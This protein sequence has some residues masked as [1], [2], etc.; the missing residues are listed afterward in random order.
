[1]IFLLWWIYF[2][3]IARRIPKATRMAPWAYLHLPLVMS[4]VAISA[5]I[6]NLFADM[7]VIVSGEVRLLLAGA[8]GSALIIIAIL[9]FTLTPVD[10]L[11]DRNRYIS[12]GLKIITGV[13]AFAVG[14]L[15]VGLGSL[16]LLTILILLML[17]HIFY[18]AFVW[19]GYLTEMNRKSDDQ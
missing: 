8:L 5:S 12:A 19:R 16:E 1:M 18:G 10:Y 17:V 4:I 15:D 3:T 9:E 14:L 6:P 2:D 11:K 13:G 7:D